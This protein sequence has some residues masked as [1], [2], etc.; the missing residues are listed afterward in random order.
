MKKWGQL[1]EISDCSE[2]ESITKIHRTSGNPDATRPDQRSLSRTGSRTSTTVGLIGPEEQDQAISAGSNAST[3]DH[4]GNDEPV[5]CDEDAATI[6]E[7]N[8]DTRPLL[9][10]LSGTA[11]E[12][13]KPAMPHCF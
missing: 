3:T 1:H 2:D 7:N 9:L 6:G 5:G 12:S 4:A 13:G 11:K 8:G 10:P